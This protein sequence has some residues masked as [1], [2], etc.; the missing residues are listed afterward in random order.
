MASSC[1]VVPLYNNGVLCLELCCNKYMLH[2]I[3]TGQGNLIFLQ[4]RGKV[5]EFCKLVREIL[6]KK[7]R[8]KSGNFIILAK[9]M[10]FWPFKMFENFNFIFLLTRYLKVKVNI[11][12]FVPQN[13]LLVC[14]LPVS[15]DSD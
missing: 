11:R 3:A 13:F 15:T 6:N 4:G 10:V 1:I 12:K 2:R 14:T 7:V 5:S 8:K 9:H